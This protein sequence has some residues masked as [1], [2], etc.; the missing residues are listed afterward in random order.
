MK[1]GTKSGGWYPGPCAWETE[2]RALASV[3]KVDRIRTKSE[4]FLFEE[5]IINY[6]NAYW[7][8][9][10][11]KKVTKFIF[12]IG[13]ALLWSL[14]CMLYITVNLEAISLTLINFHSH[15]V[16]S[17]RVLFF[18]STFASSYFQHSSKQNVINTMTNYFII[19][20]SQQ[21]WLCHLN[22]CST[23]SDPAETKV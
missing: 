17:K 10:V 23:Y 11:H 20:L 22:H 15:F 13:C 3:S 1:S 21:W 2:L 18:L 14:W 12:K 7:N 16:S 19:H 8:D 4:N 9:L 6:Y 5:G